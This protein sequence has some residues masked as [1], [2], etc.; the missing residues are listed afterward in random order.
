MQRYTYYI[1]V[2]LAAVLMSGCGDA[3]YEY[4]GYKCRF[5]FDNS[6]SRSP[7]LASAMN[8]L[9]PGVFCQISMKGDY[10]YFSTNQGL[11]DRV[12]RGGMELQTTPILG[13]YPEYG[14]IVGYGT[15]GVSGANIYAY[16]SLCPNCYDE[17][18]GYRKLTMSTDGTAQCPSCHRKYDMN[19]GG[20]VI[21]EGGGKRLINYRATAN[22]NVL[23][24]VKQFSNLR[25]S[26]YAR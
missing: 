7:A 23:N 16:D 18:G 22:G 15:L 24:V 12:Q 1:I 20:L 25:F 13:L 8:P 17:F 14:I 19:N 21:S 6:A 2:L 3:E 10:Y 5:I 11:S 9:S 4:S 26:L